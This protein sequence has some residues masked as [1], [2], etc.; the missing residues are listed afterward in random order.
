MRSAKIFSD[1][2][3]HFILFLIDI[4]YENSVPGRDTNIVSGRSYRQN[5]NKEKEQIK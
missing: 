4:F 1:K 2:I 3:C 5:G